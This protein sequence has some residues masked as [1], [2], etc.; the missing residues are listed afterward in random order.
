MRH[1][2]VPA[3]PRQALSRSRAKSR[4]APATPSAH[5]GDPGTSGATTSDVQ[6]QGLQSSKVNGH[7][8]VFPQGCWKFQDRVIPVTVKVKG[9]VSESQASGPQYL[10]LTEKGSELPSDFGSPEPD[11]LPRAI[12]SPP[13]SPV[14]GA[15]GCR[16]G[17]SKG[18]GS[19]GLNGRL[20]DPQRRPEAGASSVSGVA[21]GD[22]RT[23]S[24]RENNDLKKRPVPQAYFRA[25]SQPSACDE[26]ITGPLSL[27][28]CLKSQA[29]VRPHFP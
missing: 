8:A 28:G 29:W 9:V 21:S 13:F 10:P 27:W 26:T 7:R 11:A 23:C 25:K 15:H 24:S 2:G 18:S 5:S 4:L 16:G 14:R 20:R 22:Q 19:N 6:N 3:K 12:C 17:F 1:E